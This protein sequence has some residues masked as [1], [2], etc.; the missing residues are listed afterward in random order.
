MPFRQATEL[1]SEF[2]GIRL[3]KL[4]RVYEEMQEAEAQELLE[5]KPHPSAK[6]KK[7]QISAD[8]WFPCCSFADP[9]GGRGA[10]ARQRKG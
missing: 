9:G 8:Q 6:P 5:K 3:S 4:V 1:F 10:T 7:I 2:T